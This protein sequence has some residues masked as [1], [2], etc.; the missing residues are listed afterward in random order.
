MA[1]QRTGITIVLVAAVAF[2][3]LGTLSR[4]F[5]DA[6]GDTWTLLWLRSVAGSLVFLALARWRGGRFPVRA[7]A[8]GAVVVGALQFGGGF[9]LLEGYARAPIAL[10][11]LLFYA[12][13]LIVCVGAA[14]LFGEEL[15]AWRAAALA[16]GLAGIALIAGVPEQVSGLGIVL[17]LTAAV[18]IAGAILGA[19]HLLSRRALSPRWLNAMMAAGPAL[20]V[21]AAT[22]A[23]APSFDFGVRGW[24]LVW[25]IVLGVSVLA[26]LLFYTGVGIVGASTASLLGNV[27]PVTSVLLA[28]AVL[29][30][31]LSPVQ[32]GGGALVVASVALIGVSSRLRRPAAIVDGLGDERLST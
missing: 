14:A 27:E 20:G 13:P 9:A 12:Y 10:V 29:G 25:T 11:V 18:C 5:Y 22:P 21:L 3:T 4:L 15:G 8:L 28:Y 17:G 31:A 19:R 32:L 16:G 26:I 1:S 30:E 7:V 23:H 2:G 24:V 6:G